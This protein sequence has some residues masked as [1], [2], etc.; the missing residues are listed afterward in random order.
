MKRKA[1]IPF[2]KPYPLN[3]SIVEKKLSRVLRSPHWSKGKYLEKFEKACESFLGAKHAVAVSSCTSGLCLALTSLKKSGEVIVPGFTFP[4]VLNAVV[5]NGLKPRFVD[6]DP[7]YG[8]IEPQLI[9]RA[10][11]SKTV[12]IV[13]VCNYGFPPDFD[14]LEK[15][16]KNHKVPLIIDSAQ[17]FGTSYHGKKCGSFGNAEVFSLSLSKVLTTAEGGIVVTNNKKFAD[18]IRRGRNYG[19]LENGLFQFSGMSCRLSEFH[20]LIGLEMIKNIKN[21]LKGRSIIAEKYYQEL[22]E[23]PDISLPV[24][25]H[26]IKPSFNYFVVFFN[27]HR[28]GNLRDRVFKELQSKGIDS[29]KYFSPPAYKHPAFKHYTTT[30]FRLKVCEDLASQCLVLPIYPG[31]SLEKVIKISRIIK[32]FCR[33]SVTKAHRLQA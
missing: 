23:C 28:R 33:N 27:S 30:N 32:I 4:A 16:A 29:R 14:K 24:I 2:S 5:W 7:V 1:F 9:E 20:S 11:S 18:F 8:N 10:I 3:F 17:S 21:I 12:A 19:K 26:L 6:V 31:M 15:I 13:P 25:T 22:L